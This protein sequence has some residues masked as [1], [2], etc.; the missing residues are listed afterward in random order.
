MLRKVKLLTIIFLVALLTVGVVYAAYWLYSSVVTMTITN[1]TLDL[2]VTNDGLEVTFTA[3]LKDPN[4]Q[5]VSGETVEFWNCTD[6]SNPSG[7]LN[8]KFGEAVTDDSGVA[9]LTVTVPKEGTYNFVA[10]VQV[11]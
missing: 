6:P 1:Y 5:A 7:T 2:Q 9:T 10:R 8:Y 11:P 3:T 4:G